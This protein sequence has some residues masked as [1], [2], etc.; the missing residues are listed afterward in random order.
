[1]NNS[2]NI[3]QIVN[4]IEKLDYNSKINLLSRLVDLLKR[5]GKAIQPSSI[6]SLKGLG[7]NVW[8]KIDTD[9]YLSEE[10]GSWG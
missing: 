7:K 6:T 10:R 5:E 3:V 8:Q 9:L 2:I 1:M 4:Q